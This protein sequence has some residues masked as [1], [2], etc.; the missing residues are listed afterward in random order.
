M[1]IFVAGASGVIGRLLLPQ[2]V[3]AGHEVVGMTRKEEQKEA[4]EQTGAKAVLADVFNRE[5]MVD[6]LMEIKP[7]VVIHQ[8]TS[9]SQGSSAENARI[10]IEG[11][12]NL[13]DAAKQAK[14]QKM[15]AQSISWAYEPGT[16]PATEE[17]ALDI[18]APMPRNTTING[19]VALEEA[20]KEI[21]AQVI[22]RYGTLYGPATWYAKN[23]DTAQKIMN[24]EM[25]A[26]DGVSSF[27]H[28]EDAANAALLALDW[29]IGTYNIVD[30]EP[31]KGV[32][33]LPVY[34]RALGASAPDIQSGG[35]PWERGASNDK[36]KNECGWV[37]EYP[38]W[39]TG[40]AKSLR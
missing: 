18:Y 28:V 27:V 30:D 9:L 38:T 40:F 15:I 6:I 39:R 16:T 21:P 12:R 26:T 25:N 32:D 7:D 33:W 2:L 24:Q 29:P 13:V 1:K 5:Q 37:L 23:G 36:V 35:S 19:V 17:T 34:A 3:Q 8:L 14:V 31:A 4:I 20:V 22:L 11:T 10:R